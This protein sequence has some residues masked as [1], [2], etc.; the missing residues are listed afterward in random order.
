MALLVITQKVDRQDP[1]LGFFHRWLEQWSQAYGELIVIC[2]EKG[3]VDLPDNVRVLS[4]GK[5]EQ[6]SRWQYLRR[7]ATYLWQER[8]HYRSVFVHMNQEYV[9]LTGWWWRLTAKRILLWRNHAQGNYLTLLA[10]AL[11]DKVFCT[12]PQAYVA[13][14]KKTVVMPAGVDLR[15]YQQQV[16]VV[17][18]DR[19]LCLGRVSPVKKIDQLI[20]SI[21][22][23][24]RQGV[25]I[26]LDIA[27]PRNNRDAAYYDELQQL[28][29]EN[30]LVEQVR[31]LPAIP[32][33]ELPAF[34]N[35]YRWLVNLTPS[36][37]LDKTILE[38]LACGLV[39]LTS[40]Q[41]FASHLPAEWMMAESFGPNDLASRL[42]SLQGQ[43]QID[44]TQD[45]A[46][47]QLL[48]SQSLQQLTTQLQPYL[49]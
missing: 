5:E 23:L 46:I 43:L 34:Y 10:I 28:V 25:I 29:R 41:F 8:G 45:Q 18:S 48:Q 21:G 17:K 2:L 11:A 42:Q 36:G 20:L 39:V 1:T 9:L 40:N 35:H 19:L 6:Q 24:K 26:N 30:S 16:A 47:Q 13:K 7:L 31:F 27:G 38:A 14:F 49:A 15:L 3:E 22:L 33:S 4:L 12:S 44:P 37:S 32:P